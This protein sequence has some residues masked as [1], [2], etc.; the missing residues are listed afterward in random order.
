MKQL[1]LI[2]IYLIISIS[3]FGQ[4]T[5]IVGTVTDSITQKPVPFVNIQAVG[6]REGATTDFNGK[7]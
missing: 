4:Y 5:K 1:L 3:F 2:S 6:T 7:F